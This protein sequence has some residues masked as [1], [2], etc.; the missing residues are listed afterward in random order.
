MLAANIRPAPKSGNPMRPGDRGRQHRCRRRPGWATL[1][2]S[3]LWLGVIGAF[4]AFDGD[5]PAGRMGTARAAGAEWEPG[6][7]YRSR[8][9]QPG[10]GGMAH[11]TLVPGTQSG[12]LFTNQLSDDRALENTLRTSG[13]GVAA[14]D[15]DG[16]GWCDLYFCGMD[17]RNSR[18]RNRGQWKFVDVAEAAGVACAGQ[19]STGAVLADVDGDRDLDP[20]VN[21]VGRGTRLFLNDGQGKFT[22]ST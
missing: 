10:T 15:V 2:P 20:L 13:S 22:E 21:A 8:A 16:D 6:A 14:G 7:G 1:L 18:Y 11:L 3:A 5:G 12:L 9:L 19:D 4:G 17:N